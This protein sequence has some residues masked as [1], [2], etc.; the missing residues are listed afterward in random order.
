MPAA[1]LTSA[2]RRLQTIGFEVI[3]C[4]D[5]KSAWA[6]YLRRRAT[7]IELS[8][9]RGQEFVS[10]QVNERTH[11]FTLL[12]YVIAAVTG[13]LPDDRR[14]EPLVFQIEQYAEMSD[15]IDHL[16]DSETGLARIR[17]MEERWVSTYLG[18]Q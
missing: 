7:T 9:D 3:E 1:S 15:E 5:D 8:R 14:I 11:R 12:R 18:S 10:I 16:I 2:I 4:I 6:V 17:E 13:V